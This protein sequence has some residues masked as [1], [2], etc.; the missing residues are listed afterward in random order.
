MDIKEK[1]ITAYKAY[2]TKHGTKPNEAEVKVR[3]TTSNNEDA[4]TIW[5]G[6]RNSGNGTYFHICDTVTDLLNLCNDGNGEGFRIKE[7]IKFIERPVMKLYGFING[8]IREVH[9]TELKTF[10][11]SNIADSEGGEVSIK[12]LTL[13]AAGIDNT[14]FRYSQGSPSTSNLPKY[15]RLFRDA[16]TLQKALETDGDIILGKL[17]DEN[18][19]GEPDPFDCPIVKVDKSMYYRSTDID[20]DFYDSLPDNMFYEEC[21]GV[22]T[23]CSWRWN[24]YKPIHEPVY[25]DEND[26]TYDALYKE[27]NL[28][29]AKNA[30]WYATKEECL[31]D[32]QIE[33]VKF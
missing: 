11:H 5:I 2:E 32:N 12:N 31:A 10:I 22:K 30:K 16:N 6:D 29:I 23:I 14:F 19:D 7:F 25:H 20:Q 9:V 17:Y 21:Q 27:F 26:I 1:I 28:N 18:W 3:F 24:G 4:E 8:K 15:L 13:K 33:V